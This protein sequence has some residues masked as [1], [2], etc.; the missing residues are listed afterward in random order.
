MKVLAAVIPL[1]AGSC[2]LVVPRAVREVSSIAELEFI[3]NKNPK[4]AT[5]FCARQS[6][7]CTIVESVFK[8]L[9]DKYT[10]V[11]FAKVDINRVGIDKVTQKYQISNIP[12]FITFKDGKEFGARVVSLL[13]RLIERQ[14][15]ILAA[16]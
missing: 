6:G 7:A 15:A 3:I 16:S 10:N 2:A 5:N 14:I 11:V 12:T 8:E 9:S 13:R 4:V 1:I